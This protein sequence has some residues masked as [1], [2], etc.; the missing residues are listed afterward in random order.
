MVKE[1]RRLAERKRKDSK[2]KKKKQKSE[3]KCNKE[4]QETSRLSNNN[5]TLTST[6]NINHDDLHFSSVSPNTPDETQ[7]LQH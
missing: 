4:L 5:E 3:N 6:Q 7:Q 1:Y 2:T